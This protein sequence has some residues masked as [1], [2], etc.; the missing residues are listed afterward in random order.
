M[1]S[2]AAQCMWPAE[3]AAATHPT[4]RWC[5]A[6][7]SPVGPAE[8]E[9]GRVPAAAGAYRWGLPLGP[10]AGANRWGLPPC[11]QSET[12]G[13]RPTYSFRYLKVCNFR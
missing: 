13:A 5:A 6:P 3:S 8:P 4:P 11:R 12:T 10:T 9:S 1:A 2:V 7:G